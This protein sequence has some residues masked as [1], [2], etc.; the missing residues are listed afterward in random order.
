MPLTSAYQYKVYSGTAGAAYV[1]ITF[2]ITS[3]WIDFY[4]RNNA[5]TIRL[6]LPSG[7]YG[8]E[9]TLDPT[10]ESFPIPWFFKAKG[11]M[12]RNTDPLLNALYQIIPNA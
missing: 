10:E 5:A 1:T 12:I 8:D 6:L 9:F 4:I 3:R 7:A 11:L 2:A